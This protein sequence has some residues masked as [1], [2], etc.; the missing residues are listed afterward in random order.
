LKPG[1]F[2]LWVNWI[3]INSCTAPHLLSLL[4]CRGRRSLGG[5]AG[6]VDEGL[7]PTVFTFARVRGSGRSKRD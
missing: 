4:G 6:G 2:K 5:G 3:M 7:R 1:S